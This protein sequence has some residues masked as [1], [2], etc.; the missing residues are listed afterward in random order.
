MERKFS[1][2]HVR[3]FEH[4]YLRKLSSFSEIMQIRDFLSNTSS[5]GRDNGD[6]VPV[7]HS[8]GLRKLGRKIYNA[9]RTFEGLIH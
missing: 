2:K 6:D 4:I 8:S 9:R 1:G 3:K 5:F 7:V